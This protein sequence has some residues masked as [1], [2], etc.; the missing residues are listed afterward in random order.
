[1][2]QNRSAAASVLILRDPA[3]ELA[4]QPPVTWAIDR[5]RQALA[6]RGIDAT[7]R[8]RLDDGSAAPKHGL[9]I[10]VAGDAAPPASSVLAGAG[11]SLPSVPEALALVPATLGGQHVLLATGH[12]AR[13]LVYAVLELAD[14]ATC[15]GSPREALAA[16]E[17]DQ[18]VVEQ[19]ANAIRSMMRLF[20]CDVM[21]KPWYYDRGFWDEYL[22]YL[23]AQRF[24][25]FALALGIGYDFPRN[26]VDAY[27]YFPYP[28][29]V[30][31]PGY[32]VRVSG[33]SAEE[34]ERNLDTLRF[35]SDAAARRGLHF[36]LGLW[37]H[38][39]QWLDSPRANHV[40]EG[41]ADEQH[42]AYCRAAVRTL[43][44]A[45]PAVNGVTFRIHGESGVAEGSY[46]FWREVF[47]GVKDA[48]TGRRL[49]MDLHSKGI[50]QRMIDLALETGLPVTVSPKYWAE[51]MGLPYHQA[52]IRPTEQSRREGNWEQRFMALS[53][54]SR[55]FTRYG[56]ADLLTED[57]RY[58]VLW[59]IWP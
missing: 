32:D 4:A 18:P 46:D 56:Y 21:D 35:V 39:Y 34:R 17:I 22:S 16:L 23:A 10:V 27:F 26:V 41:L 53:A 9:R 14:R 1:M 15:A 49:E 6:A 47:A 25:R 11:V 7:V 54:G 51:H 28:F 5:L 30:Q 45:C 58:G 19:P 50:D 33:L 8:E 36:Q 12:D 2:T 31:V 20:S 38:A 37:T 3:D 43:L 59:R 44:A 24:N 13:G 57:R 40:V 55:R 29:L 42:A 52:W 48:A